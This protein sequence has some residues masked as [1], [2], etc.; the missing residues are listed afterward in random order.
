[1][2]DHPGD[3]VEM[4]ISNW[5]PRAHSPAAGVFAR[6][7]VLASRPATPSHARTLL[8]CCARLAGFGEEVGLA[9]SP[10]VLLTPSFVERFVSDALSGCS[11]VRLRA[12][13]TNLR[14]VARRVVPKL[15][16]PDPLALPRNRSK[17]PYSAREIAAFF[18]LADAQPTEARRQRLA[19]L[20]CLGAGAGLC[21]ADMRT[22][23]GTDIVRRSGGLVVLSRA[24]VA[25]VLSSFQ[26]RLF[27]AACFAGAGFV[28]G[29]VAEARKNVT[30]RL[31][32]SVAGGIDLPR[33]E[34]GRLRA[35][36]LFTQA[37]ALGLAALFAAGGFSHSQYLGDV[38]GMLP[39]P[40]EEAIVRLLGACHVD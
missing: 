26:A 37:D 7:V 5:R 27:A 6:E 18:A 16:P 35:S 17:A 31:V 36:W 10:A 1:M 32:A 4:A 13:R 20:I 12:V 11:A 22:L 30:S 29:G 34:L 19:G 40:D 2:D 28:T 25:P 8:W 38:V 24:R 3:P 23:H 39:V 15:W 14:F 33:L 9:P 21:G